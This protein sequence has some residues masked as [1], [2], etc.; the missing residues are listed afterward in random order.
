[1]IKTLAVAG[2]LAGSLVA[3]GA[4]AASQTWN[5]AYAGFFDALSGEFDSNYRISGSFTGA[6]I[7]HDGVIGKEEISEFIVNGTDYIGS[8]Q[9]TP[10]SYVG[11][12]AFNYRIGGQLNFTAGTGA[13]DPEGMY[14]YSHIIR[15]GLN[16]LD[17]VLTPYDERTNMSYE[18]TD[19][20]QFSI[21]SMTSGGVTPAVPEPGT[22]AMI[23]TGLALVGGAARRRKDQA[24]RACNG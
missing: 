8:A 2:I 13:R 18:W 17:K 23:L 21:T 1:M 20:T 15:A 4:S 11:A 3:G 22:W 24:L 16:E 7:N 9:N 19:E 14:Y 5:F 6:D 12:E 10:Y